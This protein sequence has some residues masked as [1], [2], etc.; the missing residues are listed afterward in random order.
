MGIVQMLFGKGSPQAI[1]PVT[2]QLNAKIMPLD[3]GR[4]FQDPLS[5][6]LEAAHL[7]RSEDGGTLTSKEGEILYCDLEV[8]LYENTERAYEFVRQI[9]ESLGAPKGSK[10]HV[11]RD[12]VRPIGISEGLGVYL[13]GTDLPADVYANCDSNSVRDELGRLLEGEGQVV[14]YWQG[15]KETAFYMYGSSVAEMQRRIADF[16]ATYPLC[17]RC[18]VVQIA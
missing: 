1:F 3:R 4:I 17:Q 15:P 14:G 18:R 11:S 6:A 9:I 12:D 5:A 13:N 2:I 7:G 10:L 16:L 8:D